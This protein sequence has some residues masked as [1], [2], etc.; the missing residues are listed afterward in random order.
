MSLI[1]NLR[2]LSHLGKASGR[3][4]GVQDASVFHDLEDSA[5]TFDEL[6][7]A[8]AG[9]FDFSCNTCSMRLVVSLTAVDDFELSHVG[10]RCGFLLRSFLTRKHGP[11]TRLS[12]ESRPRGVVF[13]KRVF[14]IL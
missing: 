1:E 4:L 2:Q 9:L 5:G 7:L 6:H 13:L 8:V 14:D 11:V 12:Q 3:V 10:L